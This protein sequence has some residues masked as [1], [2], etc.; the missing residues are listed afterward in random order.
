MSSFRIF[1]LFAVLPSVAMFGQT[2]VG[3]K[4]TGQVF[5][6]TGAAHPGAQVTLNSDETGMVRTVKT[7]EAGEYVIS[8]LPTGVYK[9]TCEA[10]GFKKEV[11]NGNQLNTGVG[12]VVNFKLQV[13]SQ[14]ESVSIQADAIQVELT[15]GEVGYSVTGEQASE[16]QLNGRNFP[17][18]LAL[19]P[20][21]STTYQSSFGLFGGY[22][23]TNN[24]QSINGG[25][26]DTTTWNLDGADNKDNG[27]GGN[28]FVNINPDA[29]GEFRVSTSN[30]SAESGTSSGAVVNLSIRSGT[31]NYHGRAYEYWRNDHLQTRAFNAL[32]KP[33]LRWN[34]FGWNLG[35]PVFV[36]GTTFNKNKDKL[37]FFVGQ[38]IK[39]QRIGASTTW[40]VPTA[41]RRSGNFSDLTSNL[42]VDPTTRV[43]F[44]GGIVPQ[45]VMDPNARKLVN[46]YP[47]PNC[48]NCTGGNFIFNVTTPLNVKEY[49]VKLD[50]NLGER[51]HLDF[52]FVHDYY[53][54]LQNTTNLIQYYRQVPG[55]NAAL[56]WTHVFSPS[57]VN[58]AQFAYTGNVI[59]EQKDLQPNS[60][61]IKSFL[62]SDLGL[63]M[64]T[65][66]NASPD[67]PQLGVSGYT[68]L[69]V[70]PLAFN[71]FNRIFDWKDNLTKT[72][73]NHTMKMGVLI[74]RSRKNQDN[75]PASLSG[76]YN[77]NTA[78]SPSSG[79][80]LSDALMGNFYQYTE[81]NSIRQ[82]W[83]RFTQIE[84]Y[85]QD[86]WRVSNRLTVNLGVRYSYMGPQYSAL[87]NTVQFLPQLFDPKQAATVNPSNGT[88]TA[89]PNPY[90]GLVIPGVEFPVQAKG[91]VLQYDD[92]AVKALF[93]D[94]PLGG[95]STRWGNIAPRFGFAYD[96]TG[97]QSTVLRG[98]FGA[99]YERIQ[100]NFIFSA[101]NNVPFSNQVTVVN[102]NINNPSGGG[103]NALSP[104]TISNSHYL[105]MKNPRTLTFSLGIQQKVGR[106]MLVTAT[107]VGSGA[108]NLSY[109]QDINQLPAGTGTSNFVPGSTTTLANV[110]SLRPYRGYGNIY[111]F[112]T[113]ANFTYH[114]FQSQF[115]KQF[116]GAGIINLAFTFA[117]GRTDANSYNSQPMDSYNLRGDW[118]PSSYG[119]DKVFVA[120]YVYP[121]PF[122]QKDR[123]TWYKKGFG[124]WQVSG[125][126]QIQSGLPVNPTISPDRAGTGDGSQRPN[127]VGDPYSGGPVGG[128]Q[129]LNY[130]AFALPTAG[131]FGNLSAYHIFL[132]RWQNWN[133]SLTKS[134]PVREKVSAY[135]RFEIYNVA[136]HL[137][138]FSVNT[139]SFNGYSTNTATGAT[140]STT[141]NWGQ[142]AATSDPRTMQ[143]SLRVSF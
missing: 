110:N 139:G 54:S 103:A 135:F 107:Y 81:A 1:L 141:A 80:A 121:I 109:Q 17:E 48:A 72:A 69:S 38:D 126:T 84:P 130:T 51:D 14:T 30:F 21:V 113:G 105:D 44:A 41:A 5:D 129:Y 71:N 100:G 4:I 62:K 45:S 76:Q 55:L 43:P 28:N 94:L 49:I 57:L 91:R 19:I 83:Y 114:S 26:G 95:A 127:I 133:V 88:I 33:K 98:G 6:A 12:I 23:V 82:G 52:H 8:E 40:T 140:S 73:G 60:V 68:T 131:T 120:S 27:G 56:Q 15:N 29:L 118:G 37:F 32:I 119:R 85:F 116:T 63:T 128:Y 92:P 136:N 36:P 90:N 117:K 35:G 53:D 93:R 138:I 3:Q 96:L 99:A 87:N 108:S 106:Q 86:D 65:L 122:W 2:T 132:P 101:I 79:Q 11:V 102:G 39:Y 104:Q 13:G 22:G 142:V 46:L 111:E 125:V 18:L 112:N 25:R 24:A 124:G 9:L 123:S 10:A 20:G 134:F 75:P 58:V 42:P 16:L 89:Q 70:T 34:N 143:A 78:R 7:N 61:F 50:Y 67:L 66:Y 31:K 97:N 137:S 64:P 74:M 115:R 77:Y 59:V 47:D